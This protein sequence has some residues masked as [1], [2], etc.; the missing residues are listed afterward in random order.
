M[1]LSRRKKGKW[2]RGTMETHTSSSSPLSVRERWLTT[3][4]LGLGLIT[5][6]IDASN[7]TLILPQ[8]MTSLRVEVYQVH[9]VLTAPGLAHGGHCRH[10]VAQRLVWPAHPVPALYREYDRWIARHYARLG[11]AIADL[12]SHACWRGRRDDPT[13]LSGDFLPNLS[14]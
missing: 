7:T 10:R 4:L 12:L 3:A 14:P 8:I 13:A 1:A 9:W 2:G 11:L 5:F 6:A